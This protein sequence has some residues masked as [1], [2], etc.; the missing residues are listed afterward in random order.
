MKDPGWY[1]VL[2]CCDE[3]CGVVMRFCAVVMRFCGVVMR[4]CGVV[5][6]VGEDCTVS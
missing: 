1:E 2:R 3:V 6:S 4:F 5:M